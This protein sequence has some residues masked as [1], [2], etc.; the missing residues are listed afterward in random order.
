MTGR[1]PGSIGRFVAREVEWR[2]PLSAFEA[3]AHREWPILLDSAGPIG[4]RSRWSFLACDPFSTLLSE[5]G[6][7]IRDGREAAEIDVFEALRGLL[8]DHLMSAVENALCDGVRPP[9]HGGA[10]G[11]IAYDAVDLL[12]HVP[13]PSDSRRVAPDLA[14]GLYGAVCAFDRSRE[15]AWI[16]ASDQASDQTGGQ[17]DLAERRA[18]SFESK[19]E[20]GSAPVASPKKPGSSDQL[21]GRTVDSRER[22]SVE[23]AIGRVVEYVH[24]GDIYQANLSQSFGVTLP[25]GEGAAEVYRRAREATPAPFGACMRVAGLEIV[26]VSPERFVRSDGER[27]ETRPIKGTRPRREDPMSDAAEATAL[28]V[29]AKDR[30]ENVMIVDLMRNDLSR[31]CRDGSVHV[32]SLCALESHPTVHHLVSTISGQLLPSADSVDVLRATFPAGSITGAP[33]VR[34]MEI[35]AELEAERR[36]VYCGSIGYLGFDAVMDLSVAIRTIVIK[37][38]R[39]T[40][41]AGGGIVADSEPAAEFEEML[42]KV[43]APLQAL[44]AAVDRSPSAH[45]GVGHPISVARSGSQKV[46]G[47]SVHGPGIGFDGSGIGVDHS[48]IGVDD[49]DIGVDG[50]GGLERTEFNSLSK[51]HVLI[52][53]NYDSFVYTIARYVGE[54]GAA[55]TVV[56]NDAVSLDDI[57]ALD[58]THIIISPGPRTPAEAG[59]SIDVIRR[60]GPNIPILG[61]CLGHQA[62]AEAYGG[63]V[64]RGVWPMHGRRSMIAHHGESILCGIPSPIGVGRYH[65]LVVDPTDLPSELEVIARDQDGVIMAL[66]HRYHPVV[67]VQF[68]PESILTDFGHSMLARF[69]D[70][71]AHGALENSAAAVENRASAIVNT[72]SSA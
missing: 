71:S 41:R 11:F 51:A 69:I 40:V 28:R 48:S 43:R 54:I 39:A 44:G 56:R 45:S 64:I 47:S 65:S 9:F 68:H 61:I 29:S 25:K 1:R 26:S 37:D 16:I 12:E 31:V 2:D 55:R 66:R 30:A 3:V 35:I 18:Q 72:A 58:P 27:V 70:G 52:I 13:P 57:A 19:L 14:I 53:D 62:I 38:G 63:K 36:G 4:P 42:D 17:S 7:V 49:S 5:D 6:K 59:I 67:G 32:E 24:A 8:S 50:S 22:S 46:E 33:K 21:I 34:A 23:A 20:A 10:M 15:R 60:Y